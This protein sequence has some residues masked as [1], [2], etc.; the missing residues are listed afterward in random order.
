MQWDFITK[1]LAS[2]ISTNMA[3]EDAMFNKLVEMW[4]KTKA[5]VIMTATENRELSTW[6]LPEQLGE[7][8]QYVWR[9]EQGGLEYGFALNIGENPETG[10]VTSISRGDPRLPALFTLRNKEAK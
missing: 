4:S 5:L 10:E 9:K 8:A 2:M 6:E 7:F 1:M 3:G